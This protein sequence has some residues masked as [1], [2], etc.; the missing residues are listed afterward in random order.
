MGQ[1]EDRR[2]KNG[3]RRG[4]HK[5]LKVACPKGHPYEGDNLLINSK[6]HR[7]CRRCRREGEARRRKQRSV[8]WA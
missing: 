5:L 1:V 2:D 6:G 8:S 3:E 4:F 7:E